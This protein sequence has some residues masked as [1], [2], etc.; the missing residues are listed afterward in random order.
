M[1]LDGP[2]RARE[3]VGTAVRGLGRPGPRDTIGQRRNSSEHGTRENHHVSTCAR[4]LSKGI[5]GNLRLNNAHAQMQLLNC[6]ARTRALPSR[7]VGDAL[8]LLPH[9]ITPTDTH[10]SSS[11]RPMPCTSANRARGHSLQCAVAT[12]PSTPTVLFA[13]ATRCAPAPPA[14]P[15]VVAASS[16]G[17][18][19]ETALAVEVVRLDARRRAQNALRAHRRERVFAQ[20]TCLDDRLPRLDKLLDE[21]VDILL[22]KLR[23]H[24]RRTGSDRARISQVGGTGR[25]M[26]A[27]AW[28]W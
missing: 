6:L 17:E 22:P 19:G 10:H 14:P 13:L 23:A 26:Q 12:E 4:A 7:T 25:C 24:A 28:P 9:A 18:P 15:A 5:S 1:T 20:P 8:V 2:G 3:S 27:C 16:L 21:L 11:V